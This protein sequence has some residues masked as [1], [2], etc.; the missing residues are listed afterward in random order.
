LHVARKIYGADPI[1]AVFPLSMLR[2]LIG[3]TRICRV[4]LSERV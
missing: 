3:L 1:E 2:L 4:A